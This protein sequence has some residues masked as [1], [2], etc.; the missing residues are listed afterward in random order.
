RVLID[1]QFQSLCGVEPHD[2]RAGGGDIDL[3]ANQRD[4]AFLLAEL[5][6]R[7]I[8]DGKRAGYSAVQRAPLQAALVLR[9]RGQAAAESE[10]S[11]PLACRVE[12]LP[13]A[14]D[15]LRTDGIRTD[16]AQLRQ[17]TH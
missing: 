17:E 11:P 2:K 4:A 5:E 9:R 10:K 7:G 14:D 16:L 6:Q 12:R 3:T 15:A 13:A 8:G 1:P